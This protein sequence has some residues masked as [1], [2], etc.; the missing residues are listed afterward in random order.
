MT[1]NKIL[2][3]DGMKA[4]EN[5]PDV[6]SAVKAVVGMSRDAYMLYEYHS[7]VVYNKLVDEKPL[8]L[9]AVKAMLDKHYNSLSQQIH[10]PEFAKLCTSKEMQEIENSLKDTKLLTA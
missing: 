5:I 6:I 2:K 7:P 8:E 9:P 3:I 1:Q 10:N 4:T